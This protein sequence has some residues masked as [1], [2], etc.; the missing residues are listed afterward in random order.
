MQ[1]NFHGPGTVLD[2]LKELPTNRETTFESLKSWAAANE[3]SDGAEIKL[4]I[5]NRVDALWEG[6]GVKRSDWME[7]AQNWC[8]DNL[9]EYIE[10]TQSTQHTLRISIMLPGC[11]DTKRQVPEHALCLGSQVAPQNPD[12]DAC[13]ELEGVKQGLRRVVL[14]LEAHMWPGLTM[15]VDTEARP[16]L[17]EAQDRLPTDTLPD[18]AASNVSDSPAQLPAP[19]SPVSSREIQEPAACLGNC[20]NHTGNYLRE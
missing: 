19:Y 14:A 15:K 17:G 16:D 1:Q 9:Y 12:I 10:V 7:A 18:G 13:L 6:G 11:G 2:L 5:A 20:N 3:T 4:C 8:T